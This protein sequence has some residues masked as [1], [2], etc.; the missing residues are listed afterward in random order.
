MNSFIMGVDLGR[1]SDWTAISVIEE[2][3]ERKPRPTLQDLAVGHEGDVVM[4][5]LYHL[6][7]LERPDVGTPYDKIIELVASR[8]HS[9]G[10]IDN[11]DLVVDA[12]GVG[13]PVIDLMVRVG[14][15]PIPVTITGGTTIR[16]DEEGGY[17][18][19]KYDLVAALQ[20][21]WAM[22]RLKIAGKLQ[23]TEIFLR[24]LQNFVPKVTASN[25]VSY[26]ALR[27]GDHDDLVISV[28]LAVWWA[29]YSR[30]WET[31]S[32]ILEKAEEPYDPFSYLDT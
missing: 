32:N 31:R 21:W 28:A 22:G 1:L 6:R 27:E 19:P 10:L 29:T 9:P 14:L 15:K 2:K 25:N 16:M 7:H 8:I 30:P 18:V 26:E 5:R 24:E 20:A 3:A 17:H 4:E 11:C 13:R 12:T 23:L